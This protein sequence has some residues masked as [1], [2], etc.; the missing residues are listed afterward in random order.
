MDI[1]KCINQRCS[2]RRFR[3]KKPDWKDI[4]KAIESASKAPLAGNIPTIKFILVSDKDKISELAEASQQ[5][6]ISQVDYV[7]A[8]CSDPKQCILS[9]GERG[10][11]YAKHQ[12]G[13]AIENFLLKL[14]SLGLATCWTG[15]FSDETVKRVLQLPEDVEPEAIFPIGYAFEKRKQRKKPDLDSVLYFDVWKNKY[16][17]KIRKPEAR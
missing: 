8:V 5:D 16:M 6:F 15:A 3:S 4:I 17:T 9:Y 13:A 14:E 12:A 7:I 1:D 10:K 2:C 11:R